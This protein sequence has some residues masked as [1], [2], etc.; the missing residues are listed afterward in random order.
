MNYSSSDIKHI[1]SLGL[2]LTDV[3]K[4]LEYYESPPSYVNLKSSA[5]IGDGILKLSDSEEQ[6]YIDYYKRHNASLLVSKRKT[7]KRKRVN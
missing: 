5:T 4:Q 3:E 1:D 6:E 2:S 7:Q